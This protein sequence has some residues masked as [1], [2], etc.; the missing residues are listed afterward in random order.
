MTADLPLLALM[1]LAT[2]SN[3]APAA[4]KPRKRA[5][6]K[7]PTPTSPPPM[8]AFQG[9]KT[10]PSAD[11]GKTS[12]PLAEL[13]KNPP[14]LPPAS[15]SPLETAKQKATAAIRQRTTSLLRKQA[16]SLNPFGKAQ[17][18]PATSSAM[19][20]DLQQILQKHGVK[21]TKDGLYGPKTASAWSA[22]A[23][24]KGLA[25]SISREG[26]KVAKIVTQTFESLQTPPIP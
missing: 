10:A 3:T 25:P 12:T 6:P 1:W 26:P 8:P 24:R 13:H 2:R 22:L 18:Q 14:K 9:R 17:A 7:W 21:I 4:A 15:Q 19:V 16:L 11:P 5:E 23:K 20:A